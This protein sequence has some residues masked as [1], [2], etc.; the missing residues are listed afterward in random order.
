MRPYFALATLFFGLIGSPCADASPLYYTVTDLGLAPS[1]FTGVHGDWVS[2]TL[3]Q[4]ANGDVNGVTNAAGTVT[5]AF[6]KSTVV[7]TVSPRVENW[8]F[9]GPQSTYVTTFQTQGGTYSIGTSNDWWGDYRTVTGVFYGN[10]TDVN[11]HGQ[12]VGGT[13]GG[14]ALGVMGI[15]VVTGMVGLLT[16][17]SYQNPTSNPYFYFTGRGPLID[18]LGRIL[19]QGSDGHEYLLTPT[20]LGAPQTVPEP[21]TLLI[22]GLGAAALMA[23]HARRPRRRGPSAC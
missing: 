14:G 5:Y 18:D 2:A 19:A 1:Q 17:D 8:T 12:M 13:S 10:V 15:P 6:Q 21:S 4:D 3:T 22:F 23:H 20:S 11:I 7:V 16:E 9:G